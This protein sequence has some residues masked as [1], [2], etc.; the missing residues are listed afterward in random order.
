MT[1]FELYLLFVLMPAFGVITGVTS[2]VLFVCWLV[3]VFYCEMEYDR[4]PVKTVS[5]WLLIPVVTCMLVSAAI[6]SEKQIALLVGG[7]YAMNVEGMDE[8]PENVVNALN[9][10]LEQSIGKEE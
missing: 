2:L 9:G 4:L 3:A 7:H 1:M 8:L 5:R 10:Y 6:P